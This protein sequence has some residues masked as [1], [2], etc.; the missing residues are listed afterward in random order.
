MFEEA[1]VNK[2][3]VEILKYTK[4][5]C[6]FIS[7]YLIPREIENK[8]RGPTLEDFVTILTEGSMQDVTVARLQSTGVQTPPPPSIKCNVP[9]L[10]ESL[11]EANQ[12]IPCATLQ[13]RGVVGNLYISLLIP[14]LVD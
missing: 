6:S 2:I 1:F 11:S 7:L 5:Y 12:N 9:V 3:P 13:R 8:S 10:R 4:Y 14:Y